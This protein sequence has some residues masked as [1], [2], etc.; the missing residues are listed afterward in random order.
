MKNKQ[1]QS[2]KTVNKGFTLIELL[3][4]VLIIGI[5]AAIALP[6]YKYAVAK[7]KF[8][9]LKNNTRAIYDAEQRYFL[10]NN[11]YGIKKNLD[12][13]VPSFCSVTLGIG[14]NY[15]H[16]HTKI[17]GIGVYYMRWLDSVAQDCMTGETQ[18][19]NDI[20]HRLCQDESGRKTPTACGSQNCQYIWH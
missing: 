14:A 20:T 15:V 5:L 16:C 12:V 17:F 6:Q 9:T 7:S 4:V 13:D 10:V 19:L 11:V 18:N 1:E 8:A 2:S 3:V